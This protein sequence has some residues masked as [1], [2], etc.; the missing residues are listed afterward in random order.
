MK[1]E[2]PNKASQTLAPKRAQGLGGGGFALPQMESARSTQST[3]ATSAL[4]SL[5]GLD[6]LMALQQF[7]EVG[8]RRKRAT[9]RANGLLETLDGL[10]VAL[11]SGAPSTVT[12][13]N[14]AALLNEHRDTVDDARLEVLLDEIDL[15]AQVELAKLEQARG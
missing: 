1:I 3:Q 15:R 5:A 12:A 6:A 2:A 14:L 13:T 10:R 9:R 7:E 8:E 4:G 11:L